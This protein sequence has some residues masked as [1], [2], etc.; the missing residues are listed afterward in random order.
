MRC[1]LLTLALI[2]LV[3]ALAPGAAAAPPPQAG[4]SSLAADPAG[5][6]DP[7]EERR[8]RFLFWAYT[9]IWALLAVFLVGLWL[10][11]RSVG[12]DLQQLRARLEGREDARP[13]SA[14]GA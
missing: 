9:I 6:L 13:S 8:L 5:G 2:A 4:D 1:T 14:G 3:G 7:V 10:R 12:R 11:L